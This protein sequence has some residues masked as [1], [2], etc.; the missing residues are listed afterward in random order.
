MSKDF[1]VV[2]GARAHNLKNIDVT[3]PRNQ[4]VVVTGL[5]GSGKSSLAFDTIYAEGQRRYVESLSAYARQFLGQMDKPD[6]DTIEGLSPAISIDQKT[7]SRNPRSTVGT[8]TEIYDY[9]RLLFAR[10]GTPICPNHG[11]EITSQTVEQMVDRVLEYPERTKLQVLAPIVS[12]RKGAHVKVLEDIKKQ[13][14]VRVRVDGEMLDVSEEI[15]LDKNKKHSIEVVIDR[16]VV[17]EGVASRLADSLESALKL[18]GGRV[19]IDVIG[20]EELLFSEHHACPHCGFSIG[21]LE[22]RMFSFNS[23]FGACPSCDGLGSKLEVDLELVIPNWDLSLNGHAIAPWEPTSSQY[24]PQ[25]LQSVCNHYGIDMDM[26]VK[27]IPKGLF[28]KVLYG[29]GEEKVYFRYVNDFGQVKESDILFE[30]VIPNIERRYRETSSDYIREQMEKYMAEQACPKCKGGRL[31]PESLAVFVGGKTIADVTKYSVQEVYD[32]FEGIELT[33]KQEKIARLI[34]REIKERVS[35]LINVGLDYLTLSR[36]AGTLSGGEAQRI[37]LATQIG[38]RLTGVLYILDEPSIGLHQRDNDR[39][40]RTLQ[41]MRDLGNTLIVVEH[42]EDTMMAAD[43]LLDIGPGAGIHGGQ[44]VSSG[45]PDEV[46]NDDNSLTGQYLSGKKFIPVPLERRKGDGRKVEII[47]AKENNLKNAKMSFP[48][49]TFVAVTGVSGSGKSTMI[50]EVLYKS[51]AQKLYK[52][53]SK[54]GA[55]KE[56]KGLEHLD[57]VIDIDQS[58]IG[59]TPRSN[60]ATYTGVFDDIRDVFA[61]TNEAKVRGYQKGRFSFNV[62]GGRCEACRGDGIIKIEMHFLPDVYVPCEVCHG[63]RYNRE[64]L[65]VKYKD[66][67]ISEVLGMTIEDGVEFFANIPKIKRKL[68]TLVDVGLGYMKLGQPATTL[69]GGE[70][71]RVKLASELHRRSTGRTL[72][73]LDEPTTGLHAHDIARLLEVLQRLVESGETVLVIEHNL[74]VIKT[75]DY[76]V[77]LGPEG[78]DKGGQI[79][80][81]GTPEQ[82]VK[83]ERSYTGKYLKEILERDTARMKE[84]MNEVEVG[85]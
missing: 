15:M 33:E 72:Y 64:T 41:E 3:I 38:S 65:E 13:G 85:S 68:Q 9:L 76:I 34:L 84:K 12:G 20:E 35:F 56:I 50:N 6:V 62:K 1:I 74:D 79:I 8:V 48:L 18:G 36:A 67:N 17:K 39:L 32:F 75:A 31:K 82:V 53:K 52:A 27:D 30:G 54:P 61:Q 43:Y 51:L 26:P 22:P 47:G 49:G 10:I 59:R 29:S 2:K 55:H 73:I 83:E 44:V 7:T 28:D 5:S 23:P 69:S 63:K 19:L 21:E 11:I 16:I 24:Y 78:G 80:A 40:I 42:D 46:M 14:Y 81:S 45:S 37:R 60:P 70:A 66:K 57:K 25:L 58:P 71:Q 77:D 4:L